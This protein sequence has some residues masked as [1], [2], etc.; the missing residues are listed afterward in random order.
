MKITHDDLKRAYK[1][2]IRRQAPPSREAC[3]PAESIFSVFDE[4]VSP[5]D[6]DKVIDHITGC[7]HCLLEFELFLGF[8]RQEE[9]AV[10][11]FSGYFRRQESGSAM[12]GKKGRAW[13]ILAIPRLKV[14]PRWRLVGASLVAIS[15]MVLSII[16]IRSFFRTPGDRERGRLPGQ[17]QLI[18][19]VHGER[20]NEPLVFRW[21]GTARA[22][23]YQLEI[24]DRSLLPL[25]K[26]PRVEGLRYEL[27]LEAVAIIKK[28]EVYFWMITAWLKDGTKR[29]STL[30]EFTTRE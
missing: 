5:T 21:E 28:K 19:P 26:S 11:D 13:D 18:S 1:S 17:V 14:R 23:Y 15:I 4:S 8:H 30:E 20:I 25:W 24:F 22:E 16:G 2:H 10:G 6:K 29:E 27:P 3:P 9:K 7:C 12:S